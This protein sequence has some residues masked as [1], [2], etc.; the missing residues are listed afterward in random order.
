M[1]LNPNT[2]LGLVLSGGGAKGAYQAGILKYMAEQNIQPAMVSG[3]SIGALNAAVIS[4]QKDISKASNVISDIWKELS[5]TTPVEIKKGH[6]FLSSTAIL[7]SFSN[8]LTRSVVGSII[9]KAIDKT[10]LIKDQPLNNILEDHASVELLKDGL[11]LYVSLYESEGSGKDIIKYFSQSLF[12]S[13]SKDSEFKHIQALNSDIMHEAIMASAALPYLFKAQKVEGKKYRDGG[14]GGAY[15]DQ[16]NTPA[17]PLAEAGCT[18]LIV[19][20]LDDG[21]MFDRHNK[22][23]KDVAIIEVRPKEFISTSMLDML[24]FTPEKIQLWMLQGYEDAKRCIGNSLYALSIIKEH[25]N[26]KQKVTDVMQA[27]DDDNFNIKGD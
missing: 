14:M 2:K 17:Q 15:N 9:D 4:A 26:T 16:G 6:L 23:Y 18:H 1:S 5:K 22:I 19:S 20:L 3:T 24:A 11:P 25:E 13:L 12:N 10:G 27:L 21:S 8:I 7:L